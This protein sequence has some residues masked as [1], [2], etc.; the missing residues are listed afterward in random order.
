MP[1]RGLAVLLLLFTACATQ[2][3]PQQSLRHDAPDQAAEHYAMRRAGTD[4]LHR[5]YE[6]ARQSMRNMTRHA[7]IATD[8]AEEPFG[9]WRF[10]GPGN[11]GGR[12][13]VVII[14]PVDPRVMYAAGVSGGIWKTR[15]S[16]A[17]WEAVGDRLANIAVNSMALHP[18]DRN[19]LYAGTG[20]GYFREEQRGTALPLRGN[21][22][23][24]SRDG[25]ETWTQLTSTTTEDFHWVNDLVI[26][27]H[28]PSRVYAATRT[29]V[30]RSI[31]AGTNW[32]KVF[33]TTVKG[34][35]LDLAYRGD[36]AGDF[37]FASCGTFEQATIHRTANAETDA[38]WQAV[39]TAPLMGRTTLAIAPSQ[40][41]TIYALSATNDPNPRFYQAMLAVWRS[42]QN[43]DAGTWTAQ[44]TNQSTDV[45]GP[46]LLTNQITVANQYCEGVPQNPVTMGWYCNTIAVD[47]VDPERVW[48]GGVDLFRSDNGGRNWGQASYW[49]AEGS[50]GIPFVHADQH[51]I[52]FHPQ[53]DGTTNRIAYFG[54]DGGVY[55]TTDALATTISGRDA[56][57]APVYAS[58]PFESLNSNIGITQFYHGAVLPDGETFFGGAQDNGTV[59]GTFREGPNHWQ[60]VAGGDGGYVAIDVN[61][62][63]VYAESQGGNVLRS[64]NGGRNFSPYRDGLAG[65]FLFI[66]PLVADPNR[67][68]VAWIGGSQM[69]RIGTGEI[70]SRA[71]AVF[72][73]GGLASAFAIAPGNS[74]RMIVGTNR[75]SIFRTSNATRSNGFTSW[76]ATR[77]REGFVSSVVFDPSDLNVIYATYAGFGGAHVWKSTDGGIT[78]ISRDGIDDG[79]LPDIPV[80]SIAIDPTR[81]ERLYL[82]TDLGVFV[83]LDAGE[84]WSVE[85]TGFAAAVTEAVF[86]GP[87]AL[88]PAVYAFTHGRGAWRAELVMNRP[89]QR[90]VRY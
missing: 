7:T 54:N 78:W 55:R 5:S 70:W 62:N 50:P 81:R 85:N 32:T 63:I 71:S 58:V 38:A 36:T 68:M 59:R 21:G 45:L 64:A 29:G 77:P 16:G 57:C 79:T 3:P 87:G 9:K 13:R 46:Y 76:D 65:G 33:A 25:A 11:I 27:T 41:S 23:F 52:V 12:T 18:T 2:Q 22:I 90:G 84:H 1:A 37:L 47:P 89:R 86:I 74:D 40:P 66:P 82:G 49:W 24:I 75:G 19:V 4:D 17:S 53:Y 31:D 26:S 8:A 6:I 67:T 28:D 83:S 88:G 56:M 20:E 35:C 48:V 60:R 72:S 15:S 34:G 51:T 73:D 30:W 61:P 44:V 43:G 39:H 10:L 42:D 80:H 14:D 69:W